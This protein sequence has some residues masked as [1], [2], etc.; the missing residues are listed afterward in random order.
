[1]TILSFKLDQL[2]MLLGS[3]LVVEVVGAF[4]F[5]S[6]P[7]FFW[8]N[9]LSIRSNFVVEMKVL[10]LFNPPRWRHVLFAL[11]WH[12]TMATLLFELNKL[13]T[14]LVPDLFVDVAGTC[15]ART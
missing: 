14:L 12:R 13:L 11:H 2:F 1:M 9:C 5:P 7:N 3:D 10:L 8:Q 15:L 4:K 6:E